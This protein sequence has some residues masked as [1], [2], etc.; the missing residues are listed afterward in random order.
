MSK[1]MSITFAVFLFV[2]FGYAGRADERT[3]ILSAASVTC[4]GYDSTTVPSFNQ[5]IANQ[6]ER[7]GDK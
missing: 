4:Q 6:I 1:T 3:T 5:C 7:N 2:A